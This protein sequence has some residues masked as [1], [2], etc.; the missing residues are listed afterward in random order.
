MIR[1]LQYRFIAVA[2]GSLLLVMMIVLGT[3]NFV[4]FYTIT[5]SVYAKLE[6]LTENNYAIKSGTISGDFADGS[7]NDEFPY[8]TRYFSIALSDDGDVI[9]MDLDHIAAINS[10]NA[11]KLV[12]KISINKDTF[13]HVSTGRRIY[14]YQKSVTS[15]N[16]TI[17]VFLDCTD[18]FST[19]N[20]VITL[21]MTIGLISYIAVFILVSIA[22]KSVVQPTIDNI[23]K[24]KQFITNA[25]HELKT[26]LAI[27]SANTE[28]LQMMSGENEWT[29]STMNQVKRMSALVNNL[30][31]LARMEERGENL[32]INDFNISELAEELA[33]SFIAVA[34][35]E[36]KHITT[37]ITENLEVSSDRNFI[38]ELISILIDNAVKYCDESGEINISLQ[39]TLKSVKLIVTNDYEEGESID[40]RRFFERFYRADTSHNSNKGGYGIGLSMA[41][42]ITSQI[43]G[44]ISAEWKKGKISF[45][46]VIPTKS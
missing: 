1:R 25:G 12:E 43:K 35:N 29:K 8:E 20:N 26:P 33:D 32:V 22:S 21:C 28:V 9:G 39:P 3:I 7:W 18:E 19:A 40:Y 44:K 10:K 30:I 42:E 23:E 27:I 37:S 45:I 34:E 6:Y 41:Q 17:L 11:L 24:Q 5:Q 46:V 15:D 2:M 4:N 36:G 31:R 13:G 16:I 14:A 38:H